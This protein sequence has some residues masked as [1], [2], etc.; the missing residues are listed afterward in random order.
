MR[1]GELK[2]NIVEEVNGFLL[3]S[4]LAPPPLP[5]TWIEQ[6][7]HREKK[8]SERRKD[9]GHTGCASLER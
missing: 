3:S 8:D 7:I 2:G 1:G 4:Y 5:S 6:A 9:G